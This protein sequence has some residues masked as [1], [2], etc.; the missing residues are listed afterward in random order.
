MTA[1]EDQPGVHRYEVRLGSAGVEDFRIVIEKDWQ[2]VLYPDTDQAGLGE[3]ALCGPDGDGH[4]R[5][6]RILGSPGSRYQI[7]LDLNGQDPHR[8]V[9]WNELGWRGR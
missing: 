6:W 7:S 1:D 5:C 3:G 9:Y 2:L 8:A 4:D